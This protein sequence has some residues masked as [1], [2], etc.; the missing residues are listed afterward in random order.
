MSK[1]T[2][3]EMVQDILNDL[4]SDEIN[5]IND[6]IEAQQVAQ[7]VKTTYYNITDGDTWPNF[8]RL[9]KA[10]SSGT[11][12]RP[13][14][15]LLPENVVDFEWIKYNKR[16]ST[17]TQDKF[18]DILFMEPYDFISYC[19]KRDSSESNI[20]SVI[21]P[22]STISLLIKDDV[23]PTYWTTFDQKSLWFDSYDNLVDTTLQS[24]KLQMYGQYHPSFTIADSF[25]PDLPPQ[26]FS[27]LLNE[28]KASAFV[29]LKQTP[30][31]KA[32]QHSL[33]QKRKMSQRKFKTDGGVKIPSYGRKG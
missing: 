28:S 18:E 3:L 22:T 6:T 25:I 14:Q 15:I 31:G 26:A 19:N 10:D 33:S 16:K 2:L 1:L 17:D 32:E 9:F 5:S 12:L 20:T 29:A 13:V 24:A 7:I 23:A 21:E 27:Y 8:K 11:S 30:N 4:D